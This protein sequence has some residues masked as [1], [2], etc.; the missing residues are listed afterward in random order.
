MTVLTLRNTKHRSFF[1]FSLVYLIATMFVQHRDISR[2][3]LPLWPMACIAFENFFTSKTFR[4]AAMI[5]L[6]AIFLYAWNFLIQNIMPIGEWQP[7]L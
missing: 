3:S 7:F 1:Y 6:P 2:Y 5:L 4:I